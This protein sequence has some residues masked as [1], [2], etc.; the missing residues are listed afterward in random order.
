MPTIGIH[1]R[2]LS[3]GRRAAFSALGDALGITF[4]ERSLEEDGDLDAWVILDVDRDSLPAVHR[5][6]KPCYA[7]IAADEQIPLSASTTVTF[8]GHQRVSPVLRGREV[9]SDDAAD[10]RGLADWLTDVE[11][12]ALK[13]GRPI[14]AEQSGTSGR[15]VYTALLPPELNDGAPLFTEF[16]GPRIVRLLPLV[17]FIRSLSSAAWEPP[18]LQA[19]FMFDD[20]NLHWTSYGFID[21]RKMVGEATR[22]N[23]HVSVATI[24][25][26]AWFANSSAT[27]IYKAHGDRLSLLCHGNDHVANELGRRRSV[28]SMQHLLH[29]ALSRIGRMEARTGLQVARV[30]APP[31][32]ACSETAISE[33]ARI[34]FEAVCVSRGSL[35]FHNAQAGWTRTIGMKPCDIVAG[36]SVIPRFGLSLSDPC[37]ND[38]L[39]AAVLRQP[40]VPMTHHQAVANGYQLLNETA[41]FINSLGKVSWSDMQTIARSLYSR[42][43]PDARTLVV[44]MSSKGASIPVPDGVTTVSIERPWLEHPTKEPLWWRTTAADGRWRAVRDPQAIDITAAGVLE[45]RSGSVAAMNGGTHPHGSRRLVPIARRLLTEARDRAQPSIYRLAQTRRSGQAG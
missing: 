26:D 7:V 37:R 12:L 36:L 1:A 2:S 6:S 21:Y 29:Q 16:S 9:V 15:L 40:I 24:P 17:V 3:A 22:G 11:P 43:Q 34:G 39:V 38:I 10:A 41:S 20:P 14:W 8:S 23:Y 25:L 35:K 13:D 27:K 5:V 42:R 32:G 30:M 19:T 45:I 31:H 4:V 18:P 44:R 33:M 28:E